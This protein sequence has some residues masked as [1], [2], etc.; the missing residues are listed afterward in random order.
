MRAVEVLLLAAH[1]ERAVFRAAMT[2]LGDHFGY[3]LRYLLRWDATRGELV[4]AEAAGPAVVRPEVRDFRT[5]LGVGL[6]GRCA[7]TLGVV[8]A[9]D[10]RADPSYLGV[11][12]ECASELCIPIAVRQELLGVLALQSTERDAFSK[13]DEELLVA[14]SQV[15]AL[16]LIHARANELRQRDIAELQAV[17]E[18]ARRA[19]SLDL[20][21]T[22][23]AVVRAFQV[24]TTSDSTAIYLYHPEQRHLTVEAL[25]FDPQYYPLDYQQRVRANPLPIGQGLVGWAAEHREAAMIADVAQDARPRQI[26]GVPLESKAAIVVPLMAEDRLLGVIRAV[27]MGVGSYTPDHFR[28]AQTLAH[29][30]ALAIAAAQAH[31]AVRQLSLTDD[32]TGLPNARA[33]TARLQEEIDRALRYRRPL[34]LLII[35]SDALKRVNDALGH[36]AGNQ[37]LVDLARTTRTQVRSTDFVARYG[38]D[39]FVV[40]LTETDITEGLVKAEQLRAALA[41]TYA[42]ELACTVSIGIAALSS[43]TADAIALFRAADAALYEAKRLGKGR[44]A[45]APA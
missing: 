24:T 45:Q 21:A 12:P 8:Y 23:D 27:K 20:A 6:T 7:A 22:L 15:V 42:P 19:A 10:V 40:I 36:E 16:A 35:D 9:P 14:F 33:L 34:A 43:A 39:E 17:N 30:A 4:M 2:L 37:L 38:G 1:D 31:H 29:Q 28:F 11:V 13:E 32:L 5:P 44:V 18:V 25:T 3:G 41:R 26:A